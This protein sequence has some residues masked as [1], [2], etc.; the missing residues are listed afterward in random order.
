VIYHPHYPTDR[1]NGTIDCFAGTFDVV[2]SFSLFLS[3][4]LLPT[5]N[6]RRDKFFPVRQIRRSLDLIYCSSSDSFFSA[7]LFLP[8]L[9]L[10]TFI[11]FSLLSTNI[12]QRVFSFFLHIHVVLSCSSFSVPFLLYSII[13][14][15]SS[16]I[17]SVSHAFA[18]SI[19][20]HIVFVFCCCLS[21]SRIRR[22]VRLSLHLFH[23]FKFVLHL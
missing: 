14:F 18:Y 23:L 8:N 21:L 4:F 16:S 20:A 17:V 22:V 12:Y 1:E 6:S 11:L 7:F 2:L 19:L 10:L 3:S 9:F 5:E 15:S 13:F